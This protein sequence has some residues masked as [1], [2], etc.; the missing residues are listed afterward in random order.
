MEIEVKKHKCQNKPDDFYSACQCCP[1]SFCMDKF[2]GLYMECV[3]FRLISG[4]NHGIE[5]AEQPQ[6][7]LD[8]RDEHDRCENSKKGIF[9]KTLGNPVLAVFFDGCPKLGNICLC[10]YL[11]RNSFQRGI[12]IE[13]R[14]DGSAVSNKVC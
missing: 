6:E 5:F 10:Q 7:K 11:P 1:D 9:Y 13:Y 3:D 14:H 8:C 2:K 4:F 12:D